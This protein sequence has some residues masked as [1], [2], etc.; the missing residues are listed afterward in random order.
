MSFSGHLCGRLAVRLLAICGLWAAVPAMAGKIVVMTPT[1]I[2]SALAALAPGDT[3]QMEGHFPNRVSFT[4]RDFAGV[5]VDASRATLPEGMRLQ[6]VQNIA[7]HGG[8]WGRTDAETIDWLAVRVTNSS[9]VS[10]EQ[11]TVVGTPNNR[12]G[13][14]LTTQSQFVT[15]R[16]S[17]FMGHTTGVAM[18]GSSD[19]LITGNDFRGNSSD[20]IQMVNSRRA[21]LSENHCTDVIMFPGAHA[22][23]I[24]LWSTAGNPLQSDIYLLN[25]SAIG[26]MQ[27]FASFDP[28]NGSGTRITFAGNL[29]AVTHVHALACYGCSDS[30]FVD[31]VL[32]SLPSSRWGVALSTPDG[33]NNVLSNNQLFDLR[34]R[35]EAPLPNQIWSFLEPTIAGLVGSIHSSRSYNSRLVAANFSMSGDEPVPEPATWLLLMLGFALVGRQLRQQ[36]RPT[37]VLA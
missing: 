13:G 23:C 17:L 9:H 3:L 5:R 21:I 6:N 15:I 37:H 28:K 14:I 2:N 19:I 35:P 25:N 22:D 10:F 24:Q 32:S 36:G 20:G 1:T 7:F 27:G 11:V 8:T 16:D 34:G 33:I 29:A 4:N 18:H 12:G 30:L 31:N 26:D